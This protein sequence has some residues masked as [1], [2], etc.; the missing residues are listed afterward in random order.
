MAAVAALCTLGASAN[1]A[2]VN[3]SAFI[4]L[5]NTSYAVTTTGILG[6]GYITS[7]V[8]FRGPFGNIAGQGGNYVHSNVLFG[9]LERI[10]STFDGVDAGVKVTAVGG[11]Y[12]N[13]YFT[14]NASNLVDSR[15]GTSSYTFGGTSTTGNI[16]QVANNDDDMFTL[17][18]RD[19]GVGTFT[20]ALYFDSIGDGLDYYQ[21]DY[22]LNGGTFSSTT[23]ATTGI[24]ALT[25]NTTGDDLFAY[26]INV[27]NTSSTDDLSLRFGAAGRAGNIYFGGYT[28]TAIPEPHVALIGSLGVLL[29]LRRRR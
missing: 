21:M 22:A 19:L 16:G 20:V 11:T 23:M 15:T 9:D 8:N 13:V 5:G 2:T 6:Y 24:Q 10:N 18:F 7:S 3:S 12:Q 27:T 14:E 29:L 26:T 17:E 25:G 4:G 28:V 1:A